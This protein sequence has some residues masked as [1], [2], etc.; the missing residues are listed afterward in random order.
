MAS[1]R[2][3]PGVE[4][5]RARLGIVIRD[6]GSRIVE[7]HLLG[8]AAEGEKRALELV[9]PAL[10]ALVAQGPHVRPARVAE[11]GDAN[12]KTLILRPP[13]STSRSPKSICSWRPAAVSKRTV[14]RASARSSWR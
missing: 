4:H 5:Y 11:R 2:E 7:Q 8:H 14:A 6:E 3:Q 1:E 10:L 9:E 12:R 13:I